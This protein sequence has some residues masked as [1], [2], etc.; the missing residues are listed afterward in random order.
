[1]TMTTLNGDECSPHVWIGWKEM[2]MCVPHSHP[3][4]FLRMMHSFGLNYG[5]ESFLIIVK[6]SPPIIGFFLGVIGH[7]TLF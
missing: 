7:L 6:E 1:M 2:S 3:S 5:N 4:S